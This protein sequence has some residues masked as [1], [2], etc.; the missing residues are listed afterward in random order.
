[1][2]NLYKTI[3]ST[4]LWGTVLFAIG[5]VIYL[6]Y[7]QF[8]RMKRHRSHRRHRAHRA[9][10]QQSQLSLASQESPDPVQQTTKP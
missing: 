10:R 8:R 1:M 6:G 2:A 9:M 3:E 4:A 7:L 5:L